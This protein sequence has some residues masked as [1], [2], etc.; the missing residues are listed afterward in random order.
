MSRSNNKNQS[1]R[2]PGRVWVALAIM[3]AGSVFVNIPSCEVILTT[4]NP[5]GTVFGFCEEEDLDLLLAGNIPDWDLDPTCTIPF[6][7]GG[8]C[9]GGPIWPN[10]GPR[11]D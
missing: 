6:A 2:G 10:P 1:R 11:P 3:S 9:A 5:C 7:T 8:N 4:F